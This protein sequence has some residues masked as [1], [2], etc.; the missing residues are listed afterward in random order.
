M[1]VN[2][3]EG[4]RKKDLNPEANKNGFGIQLKAILLT[5]E[6]PT[7]NEEKYDE[8]NESHVVKQMYEND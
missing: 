8:R 7:E 6:N 5:I 3:I 2:D 4:D 1:G